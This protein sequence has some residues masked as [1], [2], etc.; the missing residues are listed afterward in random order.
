MSSSELP[1]QTPARVALL[2]VA[3]E[4]IESGVRTGESLTV[5]PGDF[6]LELR[7][8][9]ATF[10]TL[11]RA[12]ELRGCV[13]ALVAS[14]PL[15]ADVAHSAFAAAFRDA[16]FPALDAAEFDD[17]EIHISVLSALEPIAV[18][19]ESDLLDRIR[20]GV[21]GLVLRDGVR[22]GTFL[23]AV[24]GSIPDPADFLREL[25]H[26]AGLPRDSWSESWEVLRYTVE[27]IP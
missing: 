22:Q 7:E 16:R 18:R 2:D 6:P 15:V 13:G 12:G 21:D 23:P 17:L 1:E 20:P 25:K 8:Q 27:S 11:R 19:D 10:V 14:R 4:S 24:W 3:H 5:D 9:R 26:K